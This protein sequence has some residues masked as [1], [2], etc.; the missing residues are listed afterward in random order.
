MTHTVTEGETL[1]QIAQNYDVTVE[2]LIT[3]NNLASAEAITVGQNLQIN[4]ASGLSANQASAST[5]SS[6]PFRYYSVDPDDEK[7]ED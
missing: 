1:A 2:H 3:L 7:K 5:Q 6:R 4:N